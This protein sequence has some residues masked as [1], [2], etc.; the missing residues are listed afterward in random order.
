LT[1]CNERDITPSS[2]KVVMADFKS[3]TLERHA[4]LRGRQTFRRHFIGR[5]QLELQLMSLGSGYDAAAG[6]LKPSGVGAHLPERAAFLHSGW[7][8]M[9]Q[10]PIPAFQGVGT[11]VSDRRQRQR[12]NGRA[13]RRAAEPMSH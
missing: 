10:G 12:N 9:P 11:G 13:N 3:G 2:V 6:G 7:S 1:F 8:Q 4:T 5:S